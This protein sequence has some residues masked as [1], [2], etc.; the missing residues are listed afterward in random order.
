MYRVIRFDDF[1]RGNE[2]WAGEH[3]QVT[4]NL[5][6]TGRPFDTIMAST[7]PD[8][9]PLGK[10]EVVLFEFFAAADSRRLLWSFRRCLECARSPAPIHPV[11]GD[12]KLRYSRYV[13]V[14]VCLFL[15][16]RHRSGCHSHDL[17]NFCGLFVTISPQW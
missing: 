14:T 17:S 5:P 12:L 9:P 2:I 4:L 3:W 7:A 1:P 8:P 15:T 13:R 10:N 11:S 16:L 6:S